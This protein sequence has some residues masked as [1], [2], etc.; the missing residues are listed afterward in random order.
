M[1]RQILGDASLG[2]SQVLGEFRLD[3]FAATPS[4]AAARH[5]GMATRKVWQ[6]ST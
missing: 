5:M 6:A 1:I 2:N 4:C 3:G